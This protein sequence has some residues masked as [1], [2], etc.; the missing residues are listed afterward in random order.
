[1][2]TAFAAIFVFGLIVFFHE[3]GHFS[4]A[5][6]V[7]IKVHEF[8]LGMGPSIIKYK[9]GE[10]EYSLRILPIGGYVR[11]EGEDEA[12]DDIRSFNKK[13]VFERIAVIFAGPLMNFIL[14]L[15]L[16]AIIFYNISGIPTT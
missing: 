15:I 8:A 9:K 14:A 12:S 2:I 7:G 13:T 4:I 3:L 11:M 6:I 1:M 5:K 16:F 10:T